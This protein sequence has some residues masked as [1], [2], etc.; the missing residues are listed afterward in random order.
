MEL[1]KGGRAGSAE[2]R[3]G[4][5]GASGL[6]RGYTF[7]KVELILSSAYYARKLFRSVRR[8]L[9]TIRAIIILY[10]EFFKKRCF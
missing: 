4:V 5:L 8:I 1:I 10:K 7:R 3:Y 6:T 9:E 2:R